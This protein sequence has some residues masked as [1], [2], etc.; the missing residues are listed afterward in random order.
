[1]PKK[2]GML[3][4]QTGSGAWDQRR[5]GTVDAP[6]HNLSRQGGSDSHEASKLAEGVHHRRFSG[7]EIRRRLARLFRRK[8]T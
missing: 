2:Q 1:M 5:G 6:E 7:R 8:R 4:L 3:P